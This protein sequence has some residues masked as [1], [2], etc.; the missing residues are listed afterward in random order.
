MVGDRVFPIRIQE[1]DICFEPN[2]GNGMEYEN[3]SDEENTKS[4]S[5]I[6]QQ[7]GEINMRGTDF[8]EAILQE[9]ELLMLRK[10]PHILMRQ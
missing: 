2:V 1:I 6:E 5:G 4:I 10:E 3:S 8:A 7:V 9:K